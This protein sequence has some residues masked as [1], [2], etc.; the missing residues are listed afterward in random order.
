MND[1]DRSREQLITELDNLRRRVAELEIQLARSQ[2]AEL[3]QRQIHDRLPVLIAT[4]GLDGYYKKVNAAFERILGW[5][6]QE[7][8]AR[9][10]V[11][12]IHPEDRAAA[13]ETFARLKSGT[14]A[15]DFVDRNLC[16]DGSHRWINWTAIS[17]PGRDIVFGIGQDITERKQ[18]EDELRHSEAKWRSVVD[19]APVQ[20]TIVDHAGTI[21]FINRPAPGLTLENVIGRSVYEFLQPEYCEQ[22]R[23]CIEQ[24]FR[25]GGTVVNESI[26]SGPHGTQ[27]WYETR[28]EPVNVD[29]KGVAVT[30][31]SSDITVRK[32]AEEELKNVN[33]RL[34]QRVRE[35]TAELT[36]ANE[37]LQVE[38]QQRRQAEEKLA[39]FRRFVE[40]AT[41]G[42]GMAGVDGRII[43]ANPFLVRLL[44][45][46]NLEDMVGK[47]VAAYYPAGY[48]EHRERVILPTVRRKEP[49][50]GEQ[51]MVFTDGREHPTIHTV[52][53]VLDDHGE[54]FCTAAVITDITELKH[55]QE[56]L[57]QS[58][59]EL[60]TSEER[61]ELV[62]R[63]AGAGVFDWD[64]RTGKVYY[65]PRWKELF[66]YEE[67]EIGE[68]FDDWASRLHPD[69]RA[70]IIKRQEDFLAGTSPTAVAEYRL[71]HQDGSYRWIIAHVLAVRD[72]EGKACRLVGSHVDI[73][74]RRVA[75]ERVLLEQRALRRMVLA[76][77]R[78][79]RLITYE[80]HD[81]VAQQLLGA[82]L[83]FDSQ[84]A[85][86]GRKSKAA[87]AYREGMDGL[88]HAAA[89]LRRV[90]NWLRTPVLDKFGLTE[91]IEDIAAQLRSTPGTPEIEYHHDVQFDRLEPTLENSLFRIAQ[92]AMTNACRHS[93]SE[94][95]RVKLTQKGGEVTLEVRDWGTGFDQNTV[96]ENRFGLEGIRERARILGGK[97]SIKSE[98]GKGTV[99]RAVFPVMEA[100][101]QEQ[102]VVK[103][104]IWG[105]GE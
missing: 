83:Q 7:S 35:R 96:Q 29:G 30:L 39:I 53:P 4:A 44:G 41:Q 89:E 22:A 66:G 57:R 42:F 74:D 40:A 34:E 10:F 63:A 104:R 47:Q 93:Q 18:A 15:I 62:V 85:R 31:I 70:S 101:G 82:M 50:H 72:S 13:A 14:P 87:E 81:G 80:L 1:Q 69:E 2:R 94:K 37:Q 20:V 43:Y 98:P 12:F 86:R 73:T 33:E 75:E 8:L 65:S 64:L 25:M 59:E 100:T 51:M 71:R 79:R 45:A 58:C 21:L 97:L 27:S 17:V 88:R 9:P 36:S 61:F 11:E 28:L 24:V 26:A 3:D 76:N 32:R 105:C 92:E 49:W 54:L 68:G 78:E 5:S 46:Q 102:G 52:F 23:R 56:M 91:A 103:S 67:D 48:Q 19:H 77:D 90:M 60:R 84:E 55:T 16:K 95:V 99:V 38:V 6:E